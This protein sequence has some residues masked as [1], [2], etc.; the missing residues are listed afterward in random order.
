M[1]FRSLYLGISTVVIA[2]IG[3]VIAWWRPGWLGSARAVTTARI[4]TVLA[5]ALALFSLAWP[6]GIGPV[7]LPVPSIAIWQVAPE[8]RAF[9][10]FGVALLVVLLA[11]GAI[12]IA[13]IARRGGPVWRHSVIAAALLITGAD[14]ATGFP[15]IKIGRAHV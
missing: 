13:A 6:I 8:L 12:V 10:R 3:M 5:P 1:L 2:L 9:A 4:A 11:L 14:L 7:P 15:V